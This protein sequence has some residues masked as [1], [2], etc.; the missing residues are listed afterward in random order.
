[1]GVLHYYLVMHK[2]YLKQKLVEVLHQEIL[3]SIP[4]YI[5]VKKNGEVIKWK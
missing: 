2:S 5:S 4:D 3:Q 1:M